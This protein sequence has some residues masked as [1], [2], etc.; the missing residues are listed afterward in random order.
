[1]IAKFV[2]L[3]ILEKAEQGYIIKSEHALRKI[4]AKD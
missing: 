2:K 3:G 4:A 1:V